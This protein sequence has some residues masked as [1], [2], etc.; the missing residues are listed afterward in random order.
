MGT[1]EI[2]SD[3]TSVAFGMV[4]VAFPV[5][6]NTQSQTF[7]MTTASTNANVTR[8]TLSEYLISI[9]IHNFEHRMLIS[10]YTGALKPDHYQELITEMVGEEKAVE[11]IKFVE[12][13]DLSFKMAQ[14]RVLRMPKEAFAKAC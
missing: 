13:R 7:I 8:V 5:H 10:V 4:F 2:A 1:L 12:Q 11:I 6:T 9:G 14:N 3:A